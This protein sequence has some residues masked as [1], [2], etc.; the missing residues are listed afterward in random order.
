[1]SAKI[2]FLGHDGNITGAPLLLLEIISW[3]KSNSEYQMELLLKSGG[4]LESDYAKTVP[5]A[6]FLSKLGKT[7]F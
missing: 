6:I 3:L 2:L 5:T 4:P 1:M 7:P